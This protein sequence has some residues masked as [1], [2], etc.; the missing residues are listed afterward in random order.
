[1]NAGH[2]RLAGLACLGLA[3][4]VL[5]G[6]LFSIV[7]GLHSGVPSH[8]AAA[9]PGV[10]LLI[11]RRFPL[12]ARPNDELELARHAT[13]APLLA[14]ITTALFSAYL[15]AVCL[16]GRSWSACGRNVVLGFAVL[17][18]TF[19]LVAPDMLSTDLY[20]YI[21]YGRMFGVYHGSPY[22]EVP[23]QY[24]GDPFYEHVYW[25][26]APSFYGPLWT[27]ISGP[28]ARAAGEDV[29]VAV[30][31]FKALAVAS[32]LATCALVAGILERVDSRSALAGTLLLAWNPLFVV[33][34]GLSGH[35]DIVMAL[36]VVA[37]LGL[38]VARRPALAVGA[39]MLG[40]LVKF[41]ALGLLP[42]VGLFALHNLPN[43]RHRVQLLVRAGSLVALLALAVLWP[44]WA[45]P[46]T[47]AAGTLGA[48][49]DRY[50][51]GLPELGLGE[52]RVWLGES[53][54]DTEVPLNF[55][56][57]WVATHQAAEMRARRDE[58]SDGLE[59]VPQWTELLV[60]SPERS[61]WLRVYDPRTRLTG[62]VPSAALGPAERPVDLNDDQDIRA[63]ERGPEGSP[64]LQTANEILRALGWVAVGL[65]WLGALALG[66]R[67]IQSLARSWVAVCLALFYLASAWF[68]PWYLI[69]GLV[70][71][72]LAPHGALSRW[73]V[74][75]SWGALLLYATLGF[76]ESNLW[77]VQ[78]YRSLAVFGLPLLVFVLDALLRA[79]LVGA[80]RLRRRIAA[81]APAGSVLPASPQTPDPSGA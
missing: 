21:F 12:L 50:A 66:T 22:L 68:W 71:A 64:A 8:V 4:L 36:L 60:V 61:G 35:N 57:W 41:I 69:W 10:D 11:E 9:V 13:A 1:M 3:S 32:A 73:M 67:S 58:G 42:L 55:R 56:G 14:V 38:I 45:G 27:L 74:L 40:G 7:G 39:I 20:A 43:R 80:A 37:G 17:F 46:E 52:L 34:S 18:Q 5:Y 63:R 47:F 6:L 81:R 72:A 24:P 78:T 28:L 49:G 15:A 19:A 2:F 16:A 77:Y 25:K 62:F 33:E 59:A 53:R 65:I 75:L 51:N 44:V 29:A 23:A 54:E 30:L 48:A 26:F 79:A 31:M 76:S 70:A